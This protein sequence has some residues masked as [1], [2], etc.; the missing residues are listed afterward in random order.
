[1]LLFADLLWDKSIDAFCWGRALKGAI[2][3]RTVF[4]QATNRLWWFTG[5]WR[6]GSLF[7]IGNSVENARVVLSHIRRLLSVRSFFCLN[8]GS[9]LGLGFL[10]F[11]M[12]TNQNKYDSSP[13]STLNCSKFNKFYPWMCPS[14]SFTTPCIFQRKDLCKFQPLIFFWKT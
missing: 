10:Y 4:P 8:A 6:N 3:G 11:E 5:K 13:S 12:G 2:I 9:N 1:M 14:V 7:V